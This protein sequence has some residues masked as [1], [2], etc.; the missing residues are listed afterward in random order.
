MYRKPSLLSRRRIGVTSDSGSDKITNQEIVSIILTEMQFAL[1]IVWVE[2][3]RY[4]H[5]CERLPTFMRAASEL[6]ASVMRV[7]AEK[8]A[9]R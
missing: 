2:A 5:S 1:K 8:V 6:Y 3:S 9:R 7:G 4:R